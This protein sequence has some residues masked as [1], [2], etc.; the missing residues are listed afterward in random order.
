MGKIVVVGSSNTDMVVRSQRIPSPGETV[1]GNEFDIIQG[2]KGANQAVAAARAGSEVSFIARVGN[3]DFGKAAIRGYQKD[4]I[5][6]DHIIIDPVYPTGVAIILVDEN[7]GQN[8]IVV[9]PG[10]NSQLSTDDIDK[11]EVVFA[12]AQAVLMQ[13]EVPLEVVI[14]TLRLVKKYDVKTILNPAP[15]QT[16]NDELL[17]SVDIITPNEN[18][19]EL[20]TGITLVNTEAI[21]QAAD[22]LLQKVNEAVIIT[23]GAKGVYYKVKSGEEANVPTIKT[24]AVDTTAAG[25]VFNGYLASALCDGHDFKTAIGIANS[26]AAISVTRKGAQP[27]I[28][29]VHELNIKY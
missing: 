18:E 26:A 16:L 7:T 25:D 29:S 11:A 14:Y 21:M 24:D 27:S 3:D 2:G 28:P 15:A 22:I 4:R 23:L 1:L 9:A 5:N 13:L 6:T 12:K 10:S 20:L 17:R 19:A 8:S